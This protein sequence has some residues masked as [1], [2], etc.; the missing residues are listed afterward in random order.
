MNQEPVLAYRGMIVGGDV[1]S[2]GADQIW[3]RGTAWKCS[4]A[5][6]LMIV[7]DLLVAGTPVCFVDS[8]R[9]RP[10]MPS[11]LVVEDEPEVVQDVLGTRRLRGVG[12]DRDR[13]LPRRV[14]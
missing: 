13:E 14:R 3:G 5:D 9:K 12:R 1:W 8:R 2:G 10:A 4:S 6:R 11:A 7:A